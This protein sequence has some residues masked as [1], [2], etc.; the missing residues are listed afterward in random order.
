M[1]GST[2]KQRKRREAMDVT[3]Y[4]SMSRQQL[5]E[6]KKRIL[7]AIRL[8]EEE[9]R[10]FMQRYLKLDHGQVVRWLEAKEKVS[11]EVA[12][13]LFLEKEQEIKARATV[14]GAAAD[15]DNL[16]ILKQNINTMASQ[17]ADVIGY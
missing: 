15:L 1:F 6:E 8:K 9:D 7:A 14:A 17:L 10:A 4:T 2:T 16:N 12:E 11:R 13:N 5:H 3:D